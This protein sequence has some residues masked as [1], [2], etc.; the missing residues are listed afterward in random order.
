MFDQIRKFALTVAATLIGVGNVACAC[1]ASSG[2]P[3][4][5]AHV[6]CDT[7][8]PE[9]SAHASHADMH[10]GMHHAPAPALNAGTDQKSPPPDH[11]QCSHCDTALAQSATVDDGVVGS[12]AKIFKTTAA[13][14]AT[15]LPHF[16]PSEVANFDRGRWRAPPT[17]TPVSL[18]IR[19]RT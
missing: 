17:E 9:V 5:S 13:T 3:S 6:A 10:A 2:S 4:E 1:P 16:A 18:K 19:L 8:P 11:S 12:I 15:V 7:P 14:I